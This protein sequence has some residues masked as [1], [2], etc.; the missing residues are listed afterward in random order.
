MN[1]D[2][3]KIKVTRTGGRK[4]TRDRIHIPWFCCS[5]VCRFAVHEFQSHY[6][7]YGSNRCRCNRRAKKCQFRF[8]QAS[9]RSCR[10]NQGHEG[11]Y[12]FVCGWVK[13]AM[14]S[15]Q[16]ILE[17]YKIQ[18]SSAQ[19]DQQISALR[20]AVT[21]FEVESYFLH[22]LNSALSIA[23]NWQH[24]QLRNKRY[25]KTYLHPLQQVE[26]GDSSSSLMDQIQ[27]IQS[28]LAEARS[29]LQNDVQALESKFGQFGTYPSLALSTFLIHHVWSL[30]WIFST[31]R[32]GNLQ[33]ELKGALD[34]VRNK[35]NDH[36]NIMN[37]RYGK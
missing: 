10:K 16:R 29:S 32:L 36:M 18:E 23:I 2:L 1:E 13:W 31:E 12:F 37:L 15:I 27:C 7:D 9:R 17:T 19:F 6:V 30:Q 35:S 22:N 14:N 8:K 34:D 5:R 25:G 4:C 28:D 33:E 11:I 20:T 24:S 21:N 3:E 26:I